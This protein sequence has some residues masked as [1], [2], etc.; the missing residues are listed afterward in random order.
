MIPGMGRG[1]NPRQLKMLMKRL[2]IEVEELEGVKRVIIVKEDCELYVEDPSVTIMRTPE[3]ETIQ[4][5]GK[6]K[7]M[8]LGSREDAEKEGK[9]EGGV[10]VP[11]EDI[12]LVMDQTGVSRE[13]AIEALKATSGSP[14]EAILKI[15]EEG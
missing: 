10:E 8:P 3:G 9:R 5:A 12:Q 14:A 15:M 4:V 7:E 13:R 1:L 11:E 2:G 6:L